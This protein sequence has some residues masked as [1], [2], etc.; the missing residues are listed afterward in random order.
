MR[1]IVV[2]GAVLSLAGSSA[3]AA[4]TSPPRPRTPAG[5]LESQAISL[6]L[7]SQTNAAQQ[8]GAAKP[9]GFA[10]WMGKLEAAKDRR[11]SGRTL[12]WSGIIV[13]T[14]VPIIGIA[15]GS[16][17][18]TA[19]GKSYVFLTLTGLVGGGGLATYGGYKA[20]KASEDIQDLDREGRIKGYLS[21]NRTSGVRLAIAIRF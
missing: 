18:T 21:R 11:K 12:F 20:H 5:T 7:E 4:D 17:G 19:G 13:G 14:V 8:A 10:E 6:A 3:R 1:R 15:A 9:P 16:T 2:L